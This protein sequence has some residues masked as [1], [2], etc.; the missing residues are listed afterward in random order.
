[1]PHDLHAD[2][3]NLSGH[4]SIDEAEPLLDWLQ[5][6][7]GPVDLAACSHI[8]PAVLQL[9]FCAG[10][11]ITAWPAAPALRSWLPATPVS[12]ETVPPTETKGIP[13]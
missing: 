5:Q 9:L 13:S 4:V 6:H 8:H 11:R 12:A 10:A 1:M 2:A 7:N 3:A